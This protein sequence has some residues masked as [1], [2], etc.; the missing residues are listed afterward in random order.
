VTV[1]AFQALSH[2]FNFKVTL[3]ILTVVIFFLAPV[4]QPPETN[5]LMNTMPFKILP[6]FE[7]GL[8]LFI[9]IVSE[10]RFRNKKPE[11]PR[12]TTERLNPG[13]I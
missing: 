8:P 9:W 12:Q 4:V 11:V 3:S 13:P 2:K 6:I 10:I 5:F 7:L 1:L